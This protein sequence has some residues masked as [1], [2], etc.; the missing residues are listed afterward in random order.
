MKPD[1]EMIHEHSNRR[2]I[3]RVAWRKLT[4]ARSVPDLVRG[5]WLPSAGAAWK[6]VLC[7]PATKIGL[8]AG[9]SQAAGVH[10]PGNL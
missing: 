6:I 9:M 2:S 5:S 4:P 3:S 8:V 7:E 10:V 1:D